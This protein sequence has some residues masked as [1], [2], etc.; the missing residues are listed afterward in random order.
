MSCV[1]LFFHP[2]CVIKHKIY[3]R[4]REYVPCPGPFEKLSVESEKEMDLKK[5][6]TP[7][8]SS[9]ATG[10]IMRG[11]TGIDVKIDWLIRTVKVMKDE[12]AGKREI[13]IMI[14][15]IVQEEMKT[16]KQDLEDLRKM[17]QEGMNRSEEGVHSSYSEALKKKKENIII[18]KPKIQQ[19]SETTKKV[20]K[21]RV[22]IKKMPM[23]ITKLRKGRERTVILGCETG[24]EM[25]KLKDTVQS[26]LKM[27]RV[28]ITRSQ[29]RNK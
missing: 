27:T 14:K 26:K 18:V 8:G 11:S 9:R 21:E 10:S 3:D 1:K 5:T 23:G 15:E 20:I 25:V 17:F 19:E 13:K 4:N 22:D 7:T 12:T 2:S 16:I 6:P 28:K 29:N 24:E